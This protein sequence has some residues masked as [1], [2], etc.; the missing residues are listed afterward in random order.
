MSTLGG[1]IKIG[2]MIKDCSLANRHALSD[3][4][5]KELLSRS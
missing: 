2:E 3:L 4:V 5:K 1:T